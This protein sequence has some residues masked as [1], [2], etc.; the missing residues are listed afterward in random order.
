MVQEKSVGHLR[1]FYSL[2]YVDVLKETRKML[3]AKI[4]ECIL[5][6]TPK[7]VSTCVGILYH[8]M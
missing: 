6:T 7:R 5:L 3:V 4:E 2:T 1:V 8:V